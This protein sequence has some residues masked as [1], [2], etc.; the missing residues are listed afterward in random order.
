MKFEGVYIADCKDKHGNFKWHTEG[1]N[2]V[3]TTGITHIMQAGLATNA[4]EITPWYIG[5]I[6]TSATDVAIGD[7]M[8]SHA[9]WTECTEYSEDTRVIWVETQ[10]SMV[11]GNTGDKA[12]FTLQVDATTIGGAFLCSSMVGGGDSGILMSAAAFAAKKTG[13]SG[14][15]LEVS[16][17]I[18]GSDDTSS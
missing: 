4:T 17:K 3:T 1:R 5:L 9:G 10:D 18:V 6:G 12:T 13:D 2:L 11:V 7:V 8:G 16:Y 14:D 15:K